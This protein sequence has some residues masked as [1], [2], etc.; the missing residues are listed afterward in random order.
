ML[1]KDSNW[2][3]VFTLFCSAY[4]YKQTFIIPGSALLAS[5]CSVYWITQSMSNRVIKNTRIFT[6]LSCLYGFSNLICFISLKVFFPAC[7]WSFI[8][9]IPMYI[10]DCMLSGHLSSWNLSARS[11]LSLPVCNSVFNNDNSCFRIAFN[12]V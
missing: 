6:S 7:V 4:I 5:I 12:F 10:H 2:M 8:L 11:F 9:F 1:Y 3:Y